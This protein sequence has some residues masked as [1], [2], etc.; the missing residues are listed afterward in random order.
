MT[1]DLRAKLTEL[2]FTEYEARVYLALLDQYPATGYQI[3]KEAGVPRSMVYEALGRLRSRGAVLETPDDRA[4][5]YR[6]VPPD[7]LL[8]NHQR[9]Q[10]ALVAELRSR[11]AALYAQ[12]DED[13]IWTIA[14]REMVLSYARAMIREA[15]EELFL[16]L[17][18]PEVAALREEIVAAC[19]RG[20]TVGAVMIGG[21]TLS[22][23]QIVHHPPLESEL[24]E[25]SDML[26][27]AVDRRQVLVA[28]GSRHGDMTATVT[29]NRNLVLIVRQF[30]WMELFAQR[31]F[32]R[33]GQD[34]LS[35]LEPDDRRVFE[36]APMLAGLRDGRE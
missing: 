35:R 22:C 21:E 34:L 25:L 30:V 24:H 28:A 6:P 5:L 14:G 13:R 1:D 17:D 32:T 26:V 36:A 31:I 29:H 27:V 12:R 16:A 7:V 23:G 3:S 8:D 2:G 20:V 19:R 18:D 33:L 15:Q 11:L 4:T 10:Q 9:A